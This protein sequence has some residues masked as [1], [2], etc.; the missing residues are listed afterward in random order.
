MLMWYWLA[1][2]LGSML[3]MSAVSLSLYAWDKRRAAKN[4]WR[5]PEKR[6]HIAA[7]LGGWPG[8]LLGQKWLRHKTQKRS[9]RFVF[10]IT[11]ALHILISIL[12]TYA[13]YLEASSA[14]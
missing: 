8:A 4:G 13:V 14:Q 9:F 6:L 3:G 1:L 5:V 2:L 10:W 7:L 11:T 12:L